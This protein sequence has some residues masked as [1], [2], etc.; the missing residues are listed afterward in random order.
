MPYLAGE[1]SPYN[2]VK[3]R[4]AFLG[5]DSTTTK[6]D[7]S[8]AVMEG[9]AFSLKDC[10][11][12]AKEDGAC[13]QMATISGGGFRSEEWCQIFADIFEI[14]LSKL[15]GNEGPSFGGAILGMVGD[16]KYESCA[17]AA[18]KIIKKAKVYFPNES[19]FAYYRAKHAKYKSIY[20]LI[21]QIED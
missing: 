15:D 8:R 2:D 1:R 20:P 16:G 21:K 7:M 19:K 18:A 13:P 3:V 6:A 14:Q 12:A 10:L 4:A 17:K 11:D 9:V 5:L